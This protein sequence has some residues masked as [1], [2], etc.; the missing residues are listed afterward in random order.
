[1]NLADYIVHRIHHSIWGF[2]LNDVTTPFDD[3]L[4][5]ACGESRELRLHLVHPDFV[6]SPRLA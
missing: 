5:P 3:H 4:P 2:V 6:V 1:M